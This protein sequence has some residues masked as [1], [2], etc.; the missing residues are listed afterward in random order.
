MCIR[1]RAADLHLALT[2]WAAVPGHR[3]VTAAVVLPGGARWTGAA[4]LAG[5]GEPMRPEHLIGIASITKTMTGAVIL[6]L[7]DEGVVRIADRDVTHRPPRERDIAMV[8]QS[9]ALYPHLTVRDNMAFGLRLRKTPEAEVQTR[10]AEA[11]SLIHISEPTR[12][13]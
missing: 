6:Q 13:Y 9:Y 11:L 2:Q 5:E 10:V 3:G 7:V 4:G 12:P 1:D 8:F